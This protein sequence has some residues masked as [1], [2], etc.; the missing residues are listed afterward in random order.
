[1]GQE[2]TYSSPVMSHLATQLLNVSS[3]AQVRDNTTESAKEAGIELRQA[4]KAVDPDFTRRQVNRL[5]FSLAR[6]AQRMEFGADSGAARGT[7][8]RVVELVDEI[9]AY[10]NK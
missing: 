10:R 3:I 9:L 7:A 6:H 5:A 2:F 4:V 1:M 8:E